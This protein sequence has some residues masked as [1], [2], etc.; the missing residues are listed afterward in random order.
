MPK[1]SSEKHEKPKIATG[2]RLVDRVDRGLREGAAHIESWFTENQLQ[3]DSASFLAIVLQ[4]ATKHFDNTAYWNQFAFLFKPAD[5][6]SS[7]LPHLRH[8]SSKSKEL[9]IV[10]AKTRARG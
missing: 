2:D 9:G 8:I 1:P 6:E 5:I 3:H 7:Y 4:Y 10:W